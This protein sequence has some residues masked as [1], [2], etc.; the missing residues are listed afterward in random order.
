MLQ[1]LVERRLV[2]GPVTNAMIRTTTAATM[3]DGGVKDNVL[4]IKVRAVLNFRIRPGDSIAGV[5]DHV[6]QTIDDQRIKVSILNDVGVE[7]SPVSTPNVPSFTLLQRTI[8]QIFPDAIAVP[9]LALGATD[10]RYY[11]KL[12]NNIY[13]FLPMWVQPE[14]VARF[15]GT[16]ERI[17]LKNYEEHI[18]FYYQLLYNSASRDTK[19]SE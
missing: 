15:H 17:S 13:R 2:S 3:F 4:P 5:I 12:T 7:P 9:S 11:S 10:S 8:R 18:R 16:N 19:E 6:R 1:P 14:A